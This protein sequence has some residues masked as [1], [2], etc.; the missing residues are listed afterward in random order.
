[1]RHNKPVNIQQPDL[2]EEFRSLVEAIYRDNLNYRNKPVSRS[3]AASVL[4]LFTQ[5][6]DVNAQDPQGMTPLGIIAH[7]TYD[8]S[9]TLVK[10]ACELI[11]RGANPM[12]NDAPLGA[13]IYQGRSS[14]LLEG[15]ISALV[16]RENEG[17]GL[18]DEWGGNLLHFAARTDTTLIASLL[19]DDIRKPPE[20][21]KF[22][23]D[24]LMSRRTQDNGTLLHA[25]WGHMN[26]F[27]NQEMTN[28]NEGLLRW[29]AT[30]HL[31]DQGLDL[32]TKDAYGQ[33][34][35]QG[36]MHVLAHGI[37]VPDDDT[38]DQMRSSLDKLRLE[39]D[40]ATPYTSPIQVP[41]RRI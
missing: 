5:G 23:P 18:R 36:V 39:G 32:L 14:D 15:V 3:K 21:R 37:H 25:L 17:R 12:I 38:W 29:I 34:A 1:M 16:A 31:L 28:K 26:S 11:D 19:E 2:L 30:R 33:T 6:L 13:T 22:S 20:E 7:R 4:K 35:A 27:L 9:A 24:L 8:D 41:R 40:T 10:I